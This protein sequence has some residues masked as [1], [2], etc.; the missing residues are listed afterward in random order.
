M[1]AV[2][3]LLNS[4]LLRTIFFAGQG[5]KEVYNEKETFDF[6]KCLFADN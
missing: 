6:G 5:T 3:V 2:G 1:D 4:Y